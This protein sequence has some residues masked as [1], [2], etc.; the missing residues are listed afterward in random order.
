[1]WDHVRGLV[2]DRGDDGPAVMSGRWSSEMY[3]IDMSTTLSRGLVIIVTVA[4]LLVSTVG[5]VSPLAGLAS[6]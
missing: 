4:E 3:D 1:M 2:G 6:W 5:A